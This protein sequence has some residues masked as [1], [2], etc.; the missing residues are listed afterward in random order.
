[1]KLR[2]SSWITRAV[3]TDKGQ[4]SFPHAALAWPRGT[5]SVAWAFL[6]SVREK[7][8]VQGHRGISWVP[9]QEGVLGPVSA[10]KLQWQWVYH[11][12]SPSVNSKKQEIAMSNNQY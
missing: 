7:G 1:M 11:S 6:Q 2:F 3:L 4:E 9:C 10:P 5:K 12:A 8:P